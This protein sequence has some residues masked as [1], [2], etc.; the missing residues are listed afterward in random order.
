MQAEVRYLFSESFIH[1][2]IHRCTG[3]VSTCKCSARAVP[4][5]VAD[6]CCSPHSMPAT[7]LPICIQ[8]VLGTETL[9]SNAQRE[10]L[11]ILTAVRF[12]SW[13]SRIRRAPARIAVSQLCSVV[14]FGFKGLLSN[15]SRPTSAAILSCCRFCI[16][17]PTMKQSSTAIVL[18]MFALCIGSSMGATVLNMWEQ[19]GGTSC[20]SGTCQ[21]AE[22]KDS[23]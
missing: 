9:A 7:C 17:R 23:K 1:R 19:C 16:A 18:V 4:Q 15:N 2:C 21:D 12:C 6:S 13:Q 14:C 11:C 5:T 20:P 10:R 3:G 22:W 8:C